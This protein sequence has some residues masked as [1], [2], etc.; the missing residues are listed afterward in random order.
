LATL[1]NALAE[2]IA[3]SRE[4]LHLLAT[5]HGD[6]VVDQVTVG[7]ILGGQRGIKSLLCDTSEVPPDKGLIIRGRPIKDLVNRLPE[8][9][10]YL[11]CT[12]NLPDEEGLH[13][14][15]GELR[16]R[17]H[18]PQYVWH[19]LDAMDRDT[20]P[21][22]MFNTAVLVLVRESVFQ[23]TYPEMRKQE[24]WE[25]T[26]EDSLNLI[27]KL[28][29]IAGYIYRK[30]FKK[31]PHI[32]P[33]EDLDFGANY[34]Y[35]LGLLDDSKR[36]A[37]L[38]RLYLVLHSD[39]ESGNVSAHVTHCV[40]SALSDTYYSVSAGLNGL[41]GPLHGLANQECLAWVLDLMERFGG[42]PTEEQ[43]YQYAWE[44]LN[45]GHVIPGYGHAVLRVVDPRFEAL[46][47]FGI[48]CCGHN[49]VI[50]TVEMIYRVVPKVLK[51]Q[52]KAKNIWPNVDAISG[53]L[54]YQFGLKEFEYYTVLFGVARVLGMC[55]QLI[56]ARGIM[57]PIE[58]PKSVTTQW[59]Q[60]AVQSLK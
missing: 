22:A 28:P 14:L 10:F 13:D 3:K 56:L 39:H 27:A 34:A 21:M 42:V 32:P 26:Y 37:D 12:G 46:L 59:L 23:R 1:K 54:I 49:P 4:E 16:S 24:Y 60:Q 5:E 35:C 15:Q 7:Q 51:E 40:G 11:L 52:G 8:E 6:K 30:R 17:A 53:A 38:I 29:D 58:R 19:V 25:A 41:S 55:A 33:R 9:V 20:H 18:V 50:Q 31:G 36:F 44:T 48:D 2:T 45:R 43:L 57:E 47:D